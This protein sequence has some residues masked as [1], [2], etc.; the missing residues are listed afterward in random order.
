VTLIGA[1][2]IRAKQRAAAHERRPEERE[3]LPAEALCAT[4]SPSETGK[5]FEREVARF[6]GKYHRNERANS[7]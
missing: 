2:G 7:G 5:F 4:I 1:G 6:N 3:A